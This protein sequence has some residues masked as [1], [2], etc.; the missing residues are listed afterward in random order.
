MHLTGVSVT[1]TNP[2]GTKGII[3]PTG[4]SSPVK[5][6]AWD[7]SRSAWVD[8]SYQETGATVIPDSAVNPV[9]G[10]VLLKLSSEGQFATGWLSLA[11][12]VG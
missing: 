12:T 2:F 9:T 8:L 3:G 1:N 4:T 10:E 7:W 5:A 11:G 6:Q